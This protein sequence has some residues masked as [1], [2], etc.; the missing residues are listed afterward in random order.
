MHHVFQIP[1]VTTSG[2]NPNTAVAAQESS[3]PGISNNWT[4]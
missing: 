4:V 3:T 1:D 2:R